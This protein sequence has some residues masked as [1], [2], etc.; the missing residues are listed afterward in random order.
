[1]S[2][3]PSCRP[4]R[5][6][7]RTAGATLLAALA[8][9]LAACGGGGHH[10][11]GND[12]AGGVPDSALQSSSAWTDYVASLPADDTAMPLSLSN[13]DEPPTDDAAEPIDVDD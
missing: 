12:T 7:G 3:M 6:F 2:T 9:A 8:C 11:D 4:V 1:M 5:A 13:V 10:D